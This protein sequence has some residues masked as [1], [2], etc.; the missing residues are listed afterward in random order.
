METIV[1][2][3]FVYM[4]NYLILR[5]AGRQADGFG[6]NPGVFAR[7]FFAADVRLRG[8]VVPDENH[9]EAGGREAAGAEGGNLSG[10]PGSDPCANGITVDQPGPRCIVV[11]AHG[12]S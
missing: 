10:Q 7:S 12:S 3:Q 8:G 2:I 4:R 1:P 11:F 5:R 6:I 9:A